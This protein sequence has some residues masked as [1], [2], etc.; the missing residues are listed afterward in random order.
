MFSLR[1]ARLRPFATCSYRSVTRPSN[2]DHLRNWTNSPPLTPLDITAT[3]F[4]TLSLEL[5]ADANVLHLQLHRPQAVNAMNMAMWVE[6][7]RVFELVERTPRVAAVIVSG[8]GRGFSS[9]M[10]LDVFQQMQ[11]IAA[12]EPCDGRKRERLLHVIDQFQRVVSAPEQC[13]V[14]VI[15]AVHGPC[16]GAAVDFVTACDLRYADVSARFAVKEVD[17]AIVADLGTLQRLPKLIGEQRAKELAYTGRSVSG[18]EAETLG[19]VLKAL[20]D[21]DALL[22]HVRDVATAIAA[23][24]PLAVRGIKRTIH[25]QRDHSTADALLQVRYHNAAVLYS[26]DLTQAVRATRKGTAPTFRD[27]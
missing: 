18:R 6:L 3:T 20:P 17:L 23:K 14:P 4:E 2:Y 8:A 13:R 5:L 25:Y 11:T 24:S 19:L 22:G 26:D 12:D 15:A 10:D 16:I 21:H 27:D 1:S 7:A 9:G